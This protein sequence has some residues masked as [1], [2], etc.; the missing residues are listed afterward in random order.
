MTCASMFIMFSLI[1]FSYFVFLLELREQEKRCLPFF[2]Q[3]EKE[4]KMR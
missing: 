3:L 2:K 1:W 4:K